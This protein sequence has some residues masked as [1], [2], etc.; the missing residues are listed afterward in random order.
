[1]TLIERIESFLTASPYSTTVLTYEVDYVDPPDVRTELM[2]VERIKE[3]DKFGREGRYV[4]SFGHI[5][6]REPTQYGGCM[7]FISEITDEL[8]AMYNVSTR[9]EALL[10]AQYEDDLDARMHAFYHN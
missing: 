9:A 1:M 3:E 2:L 7:W 8:A 4:S 6:D 10:D 5:V